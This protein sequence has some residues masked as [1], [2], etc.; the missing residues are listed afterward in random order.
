MAFVGGSIG[1]N[2]AHKGQEHF[3]RSTSSLYSISIF[4]TIKL[5]SHLQIMIFEDLFAC[6]NCPYVTLYRISL[7]VVQ[8]G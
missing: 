4:I 2:V 7:I 3:A 6:K 1:I 5:E 8:F